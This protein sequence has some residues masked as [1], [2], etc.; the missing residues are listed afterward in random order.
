MKYFC[1]CGCTIDESEIIT[2]NNIKMANGKRYSGYT[3]PHH[4]DGYMMQRISK[5]LDCG[6]DVYLG[7]IGPPKLR[8]PEHSKAHSIKVAKEQRNERYAKKH[9]KKKRRRVAQK[10][11]SNRGQYC[12]L[13]RDCDQYPHC[14][15]CGDFE[16]IFPNVDPGGR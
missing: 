5:C 10:G 9:Q 1:S 4:K 7:R 2:S 15:G 12:K 16:P 3:C 6:C 8:C 11:Y 14:W 13:Q